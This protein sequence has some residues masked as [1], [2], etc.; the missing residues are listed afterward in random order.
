MNWSET[1]ALVSGASR[2]IGRAIALELGRRGATV[3]GTATGEAGAQSISETLSAAGSKGEGRVLDV[4][5]GE[6]VQGLLSA[7]EASFGR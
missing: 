1:T 2:G 4:R 3:V 6:A 7:V 5:D